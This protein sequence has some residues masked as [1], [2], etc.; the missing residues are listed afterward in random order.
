VPKIKVWVVVSGVGRAIGG[1]A[2]MVLSLA[3]VVSVGAGAVAG[4]VRACGSSMS[5]L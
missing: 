2:W 4:S 5:G 1:K 3:V